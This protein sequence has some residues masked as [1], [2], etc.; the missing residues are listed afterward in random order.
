MA[1]TTIL[2]LMTTLAPVNGAGKPV[3][4]PAPIVYGVGIGEPRGTGPQARLMARRAAEVRAVRDLA[5]KLGIGPKGKLPSF[6]YVS[7][8]Y[9]P[10]GKVRVVVANR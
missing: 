7:T 6:R 2:V 4:R 5:S 3:V 10:G 9:L 8:E 1:A